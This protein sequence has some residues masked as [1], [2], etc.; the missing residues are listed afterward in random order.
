MG[1]GAVHCSVLTGVKEKEYLSAPSLWTALHGNS[2][3]T[4]TGCTIEAPQYGALNNCEGYVNVLVRAKFLAATGWVE[5]AIRD[6]ARSPGG[7]EAT[8]G[9]DSSSGTWAGEIANTDGLGG[10]AA[11]EE[12]APFLVRGPQASG[13]HRGAAPRKGD[14]AA[15]P[16]GLGGGASHGGRGGVFGAPFRW[17]AW[18]VGVLIRSGLARQ[19]V[20][21]LRDDSTCATLSPPPVLCWRSVSRARL[22]LPLDPAL[23]AA[24]AVT[25]LMF[26]GCWMIFAFFLLPIMSE[27]DRKKLR[28][29][30]SLDQ[31]QELYTLL[32]EYKD[33]NYWAI[34]CGFSVVYLVKQ[35]LALPGSPLFNLL[36][37]G[38]FG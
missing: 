22:A 13:G 37:G 25:A 20:Y 18:A 26:F 19:V 35:T 9:G 23:A 28:V 11:N 31:V 30:E 17:I 32:G 12:R 16:A 10:D 21:H 5:L 15:S 24:L 27:D 6:S 7:G 33:K 1:A 8:A 4:R 2:R 14:E 38:L 34:I 3:G 29:P 36:G